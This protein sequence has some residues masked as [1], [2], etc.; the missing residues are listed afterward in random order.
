MR[1][2]QR[3]GRRGR[4]AGLRVEALERRDTPTVFTVT[5][6]ADA[7]AGTLRQAILDANTATG[8]DVIVFAPALSGGTIN[9]TA[10][11]PTISDAVDVIGPSGNP[12]GITVSGQNIAGVRPFTIAA[13]PVTLKNLTITGGNVVGAGGGLD[14]ASHTTLTH[15]VVRGNTASASGGG[16]RNEF[17]GV[18]VVTASQIFGNVAG[19]SGGGIVNLGAAAVAD[20][21][22]EGNRSQLHGGGIFHLS[23]TMTLDRDLISRNLAAFGGGIET[24]SPDANA[25]LVTD[26]TV[27][28]NVGRA[29][30]GGIEIN[31]SGPVTVANSTVVGN[32]NMGSLL[33]TSG[34]ITRA[35]GFLNVSNTVISQNVSGSVD[36]DLSPIAINGF[37]VGNFVGGDPLLGPLRD[38][39]GPT[40]TMTPLPGSPLLNAGVNVPTISEEQTVS[41]T[42][43]AGSFTLTFNGVTTPAVSFGATAG[44][45]QSALNALSSVG[46]V[47]G[48]VT[49]TAS[50]SDYMVTFGGTLAGTDLPTMTAAG[51]G[52]AIADVFTVLNGETRLLPAGDQR[53]FTSRIVNGTVDIGAV[54]V[55]AAARPRP[56]LAVGG[57]TDGTIARFVATGG[58]FDP[59]PADTFSPF[60]PVPV[61]VRPATADVDGDGIADTI[62]VTGP[63]TPIR[64]AVVSGTDNT[65]LLVSPFDPFGGD[66]TGGGFVTAADFDGDGR[67]EFV[68]TPDRGGGPRVSVFSAGTGG[69]AVTRANF[70]GIADPDFRGGARAAAG[71]LNRD[72][73][74]DL[75]VGAGFGGGPRIAVY[76]GTTVLGTPASLVPD[77][78]LF[79]SSV[80]NGAFVAV[81]DVNGDGFADLIGGAG[82]G[83]GPRVLVVS[84]VQLLVDPA[85]AV[86]APLANYFVAN[87]TA[88]R[89]GVR[90][91]VTDLDG[92]GLADVAT[93][94]GDNR[95]ARVR[96]YP[97]S[98]FGGAGEPR[99]F[100]DLDPFGGSTLG[101]GVYVG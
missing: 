23:G 54:E 66:F 52:G 20:T 31:G 35:G 74:P 80:R 9:L 12:D 69:V 62:L 51:S 73:V 2:R 90:V 86:A 101:D 26:C 24:G 83:G 43:G 14:N 47:G 11:L 13:G 97:G 29:S 64:V 59:A 55:G 38:N 63:G 22:V 89:G 15:V 70:F 79:E 61:N 6:A 3:N 94:S 44:V 78:F 37:D 77:F 68:V 71:D 85:A 100:Q 96:V 21:T 39:G 48:S 67:A 46:G 34:G 40:Y 95:P 76:N 25:L 18:L 33:N 27:V 88:D 42:G 19:D 5:S 17:A 81:G 75:V 98:S 1:T 10:S 87:A 92:D 99:G 84:G 7:G 53:G 8:S 50:G 60:G 56:P 28:G 65:T 30:G 36:D 41:V 4:T 93:A 57:E 91:A 49:V 45:V 32:V 82:P 72:G 16:I 58:E